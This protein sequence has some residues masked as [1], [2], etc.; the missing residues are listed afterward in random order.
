MLNICKDRYDKNNSLILGMGVT[1]FKVF[2]S[3]V[4]QLLERIET[5]CLCY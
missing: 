1:L 4:V 2:I 3:A 5:V